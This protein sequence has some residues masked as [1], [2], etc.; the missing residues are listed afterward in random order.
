MRE[1]LRD[2]VE[3][4][5]R[6]FANGFLSH[7]ENETLRQRVARGYAGHDP[8]RPEDLYRQLL[9]L[10]Y[11]LLF[12]LVAEDRGLLS[13]DPV[14]REH[15]G[16][17]RLR[18]TVDQRAAFNDYDD[19][20]QSLR[21]LWRILTKEELAAL[22]QLA[23]LNGDLF[24]PVDLDDGTI[25]NR[26]LLGALW[27]L[28]YYQER[29]APPRRV[30]YAA[31]DVEELGVGLRKPAGV[32]SGGGPGRRWPADVRSDRRARNARPPALTTRRRNW[33][34]N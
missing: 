6:R 15:Y 17:A 10:I 21:V 9:K 8:I 33:W 3:E 2:G 22:L 13:P 16:I 12:L 34:R 30:N 11:R 7:P 24:A 25:S 5:I 28:V 23:P 18:R 19:L 26:D 14:Y 27:Y 20:W 1:H 32:P 4:C 31:L 29:A